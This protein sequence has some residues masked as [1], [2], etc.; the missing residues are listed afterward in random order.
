M[1]LQFM[2]DDTWLPQWEAN[3]LLVFLRQ[4]CRPFRKHTPST[5]KKEET[6]STSAFPVLGKGL[7][8][9]SRRGSLQEQAIVFLRCSNL[10]HGDNVSSSCLSVQE[11]TERCC[12]DESCD[13]HLKQIHGLNAKL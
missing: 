4:T 5:L 11:D 8:P 2:E 1:F 10:R 3:W 6:Q 12:K 7:C 9:W 13:Y